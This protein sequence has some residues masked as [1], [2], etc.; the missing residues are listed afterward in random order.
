MRDKRS[1]T[2][3][4]LFSLFILVLSVF[5]EISPAIAQQGS[6]I[7]P[8]KIR[9]LVNEID[10]SAIEDHIRYLTS[11][12]SRTTLYPGYYAALNYITQKF[13][14]YG[15]NVFYHNYSVTVP[16]DYGANISLLNYPS[17]N[18][19]I[20][21]LEPN[22]VSPVTAKNLT[23]HLI[24]VSDGELTD[25]NEACR[26]YNVDIK[27]SIA[28]M[29]FN[30]RDNWLRVAKFGGKAVIFIEPEETYSDEVNTKSL[31]APFYFPRYYMPRAD[32]QRLLSILDASKEPVYV[33]INSKMIWEKHTAQNVIGVLNGS[34]Y[35]DKIIL[36]SAYFDSDCVVPSLAEGANEATGIASLLELARLLSL[37]EFKPKFTIWFVAFSG[38]HQYLEGARMFVQDYLWG[39]HS[40]IGRNFVQQIHIQLS[41]ETNR[42]MTVESGNYMMPILSHKN[43]G[44]K[45][46]LYEEFVQ[47]LIGEISTTL[48]KEFYVENKGTGIYGYRF[49]YQPQ[50]LPFF[51]S[52]IFKA[53]A[54]PAYGFVTDD[55]RHYLRSPL[56]TY[57]NLKGK[58]KNLWVQVESIFS[59]IYTT[60]TCDDLL[61]KYVV[62]LGSDQFDRIFWI[63][64]QIAIYNKTKAWYQ[65]VP[66]GIIYMRSTNQRGRVPKPV[67][68]LADETGRFKIY[69]LDSGHTSGSGT[70]WQIG[71]YVIDLETGLITHAPDFGRYS[72]GEARGLMV[73]EDR[74]IGFFTVFPCATV[75]L[76][77]VADPYFAFSDTISGID[78]L[79]AGTDV[80]PEQFGYHVYFTGAERGLTS[81]G[82][83]AVLYIPTDKRYSV[84]FTSKY[85]PEHPIGILVNASAE[86]PEGVGYKLE[87]GRQYV[88]PNTKLE[89]VKNI[90]Y[91]EGET[92][93]NLGRY[94]LHGDM[95]KRIQAVKQLI[96]QAEK[97]LVEG[98]YDKLEYFSLKAWS[99]SYDIYVD[100]RETIVDIVNTIP[101]FAALLVPCVYLM[102]RLFFG[103]SGLKRIMALILTFVCIMGPLYFLHPGF[104]IASSSIMVVVSFC[105]LILIVPVVGILIS[106]FLSS[107]KKIAFAI[108]GIH[109]AEI[110]RGSAASLSFSLG[111]E[112]MKKRKLRSALLFVTVVLVVTGLILFSGLSAIEFIKPIPSEGTPLYSPG[113]YV[114]KTSW[115]IG[116]IGFDA[117]EYLKAAYGDTAII[118]PRTWIYTFSSGSELLNFRLWYNGKSYDYYAVTGLTP[119][120]PEEVKNSVI[121][122]TWFTQPRGHVCII[123]SRIANLLGINVGDTV[124]SLGVNWTVIG[125]I[126]EAYFDS[127]KELG[128]QE[129]GPFDYRI[130]Q[131][132][133]VHTTI[134]DSII[135]P[136]EESLHFRYDLTPVSISV[137]FDDPEKAR[138]ASRDFFTS[139]P[140]LKVSESIGNVINTYTITTS[141]ITIGWQMQVVPVVLACIMILNI[142]LGSVQ[143]RG[144][145]IFTFSSVGMSPMHVASLFL[146]E[147]VIYGVVAVVLGYLIALISINVIGTISPAAIPNINYS[148][149]WI[150]TVIGIIMVGIVLASI[151]PMRIASRL[152]T[153]SLE[154]V[155]VPPTKPKGDEWSIPLPFL[156]TDDEAQP[157]LN[158]VS[159]YL[160]AHAFER[161]ESFSV[162]DLSFSE[163]VEEGQT[164]KRLEAMIRLAPYER[165]MAQLARLYLIKDPKTGKWSLQIYLRRES[166]R[167]ESWIRANHRFL[168]EIR[169]Q[170]LIWRSLP[171]EE[172]ARYK[173]K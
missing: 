12:G 156:V 32:A 165:G 51:D 115:T 97:S 102:E 69:Q 40:S 164:Y 89:I 60:V 123:A 86:H 137:T 88:I 131:Q 80:R 73:R 114:R 85:Y 8:A 170:F 133:Y 72:Y 36:L 18:L 29:N 167:A 49:I 78:F 34:T 99:L 24:Y 39:E 74:D 129:I 104:L 22:L 111:I 35:P 11:Q 45:Y 126:D 87:Q 166:G 10:K 76:F 160:E 41:A 116:N 20:Y 56:D 145:E 91:V 155:W 68:Q 28:V 66:N 108:K 83:T 161:A 82:P 4:V 141:I 19:R 58:L 17:E 146:A 57:D 143:E 136:Y 173:K 77:D 125:I 42:W 172:T 96:E 44:P 92:A 9:Q 1:I 158:Y 147:S 64:G 33:S 79:E 119:E 59:V 163:G 169:K 168:D 153:P 152:V 130:P 120:E 15:L 25:F 107:T 159:E 122:G 93:S 154:R 134:A 162:S 5:S 103:A 67:I 48:G 6:L 139:F 81:I 109:E 118:R 43:P 62:N 135:I 46:K 3:F 90:L 47:S 61:N 75:V 55:W 2:L 65:A 54:G 151:Y 98:K 106:I 94:G 7:D 30:S 105:I 144:K 127:L 23:G 52:E 171:P 150:V 13:A 148:S 149:S 101:F 38:H 63:T 70:I 50:G 142:I 53:N 71:C 26:K 121:N 112:N 113:I 16:I 37:P 132:D 157:F 14:E 138:E 21:P 84:L 117:L 140:M 31:D 95:P 100:G 110:S 128:G 27:D 124:R